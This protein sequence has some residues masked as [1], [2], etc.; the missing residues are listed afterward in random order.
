MRALSA[1][2]LAVSI[3]GCA[4]PQMAWIRLDGVRGN[5]DPVLTQQ[6]ELDKTTCLG[7]IPRANSS[8]GSAVAAA[9]LSV[10]VS[11]VARACMADKGYVLVRENEADAKAA[12][13]RATAAEKKR[14]EEAAQ[15]RPPAP[16]PMRR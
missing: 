15:A 9:D 16:P 5:G 14:R 3:G 2:L 6:F 1:I 12:E 10:T 13:L 7:E 8:G 4:S 11:E